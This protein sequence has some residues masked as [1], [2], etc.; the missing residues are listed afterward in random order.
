MDNTSITTA[1]PA[2]NHALQQLRALPKEQQ[3]AKALDLLSMADRAAEQLNWMTSEVWGYT[4]EN[5]PWEAG[6]MTVEEVQARIDWSAVCKRIQQHEDTT[7]RK[8]RSIAGI[9][10]Q[11]ERPLEDVIP[12][13]LLPSHLTL[14]L[15]QNLHQLSKAIS[16]EAAPRP[17]IDAIQWRL[18]QPKRSKKEEL[19][20]ADVLRALD[21][22]KAVEGR[23]T[24]SGE[25]TAIGGC[26]DGD[27]GHDDDDES[28]QQLRREDERRREA[29]W[30]AGEMTVVTGGHCSCPSHLRGRF[31]GPG[32]RLP[33]EEGSAL[34]W[35]A[36]KGAGLGGLC[37]R[38]L[39]LL[40]SGGLG[41]LNNK[42]QEVSGGGSSRRTGTGP[43]SRSSGGGSPSGFGRAVGRPRHKTCWGHSG[44]LRCSG[45][46]L[47]STR[48]GSWSGSAEWVAGRR[49][50]ATGPSTSPGCSRTSGKR[51][52]SG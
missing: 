40:A 3:L 39:R 28:A 36:L 16:A 11:W 31:P 33:D 52:S 7:R 44:S 35:E 14:N 4:V 43:S 19:Q 47:T 26:N 13:A 23:S 17:L 6:N 46:R 25:R 49:G 27:K 10:R 21:P 50:N 45:R 20:A 29:T 18:D 9:R 15:V 2:A 48:R 32:A 24:E 8:N 30:A 12:T 51:T 22:T 42:T 38:H 1:I 5:R 37:Q 41:L 34:V